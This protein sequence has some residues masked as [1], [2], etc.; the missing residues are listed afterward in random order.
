[1]FVGVELQHLDQHDV[2]PGRVG[3]DG[4]LLH[5]GNR[6]VDTLTDFAVV[7]GQR[8]LRFSSGFLF[9]GAVVHAVH[10]QQHNSPSDKTPQGSGWPVTP[11]IVFYE[12]HHHDAP[13][14]KKAYRGT[15]RS[16]SHLLIVPPYDR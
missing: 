4:L 14:D 13:H 9:L 16:V 8:L 11:S 10:N 1:V 12:V 7:L 15:A 6:N 5:D 2:A 3:L